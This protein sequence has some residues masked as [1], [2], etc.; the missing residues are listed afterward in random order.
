MATLVAEAGADV[1]S[2]SVG[3]CRPSYGFFKLH[4]GPVADV[5]LFSLAAR[6]YAAPRRPREPVVWLLVSSLTYRSHTV[7]M[8]IQLCKCMTARRVVDPC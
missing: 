6:E 8:Q 7:S 4:P 2:K 5:L 1:N 3:F